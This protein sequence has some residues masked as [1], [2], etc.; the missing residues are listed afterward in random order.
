MFSASESG[1]YRH[2]RLRC[3]RYG[4]FGPFPG[5]KM[6][7]KGSPLVRRLPHDWLSGNCTNLVPTVLKL[8]ALQFFLSVDDFGC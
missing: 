8:A 3:C 6:A 4:R 2:R 1:D 7:E 5:R